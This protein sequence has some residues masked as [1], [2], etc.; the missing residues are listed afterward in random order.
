MWVP[1]EEKLEILSTLNRKTSLSG[2]NYFIADR[3][4][5]LSFSLCIINV[6]T[7]MNYYCWQWN[8][9]SSTAVYLPSQSTLRQ[10]LCNCVPE[11]FYPTV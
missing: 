8:Y 11:H 9:H 2:P 5:R 4:F 6:D 1:D 10:K 3:I 7:S